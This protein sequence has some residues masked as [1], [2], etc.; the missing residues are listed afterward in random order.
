MPAHCWTKLVYTTVRQRVFQS[1]VNCY[2]SPTAGGEKKS[3]REKRWEVVFIRKCVV[4]IGVLNTYIW[5]W[6][7]VYIRVSSRYICVFVGI[8]FS[9]FF[10]FPSSSSSASFLSLSLSF[11]FL[12]FFSSFFIFA[13]RDPWATRRGGKPEGQR[14]LVVSSFQQ[15]ESVC[16]FQ[17]GK[18]LHD[19]ACA[20]NTHE[21]YI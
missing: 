2:F 20:L 21:H 1:E 14:P 11:F 4:T 9:F 5:F 15:P 18:T 10:L 17:P 7:C 6:L 12:V 19:P 8:L 3:E 16:S 13:W